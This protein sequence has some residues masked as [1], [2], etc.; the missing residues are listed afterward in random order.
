MIMPSSQEPT[1][2]TISI[3]IA[4]T[5]REKREIYRLRYQ[6]YV[7]EMAMQP[8]AVDHRHKLLYEDLDDWGVL[9]Y[10]KVGSQLIG[11]MRINLGDI[12]AF[13]QNL[14]QIFSLDKFQKFY[15]SAEPQNIAY[16][17][18]LMVVPHYRNSMTLYLL[19]VKGYEFYCQHQVQFTFGICK[20]HLLNRIT[21]AN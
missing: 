2:P 7:E 9:F 12:K 20:F 8:I 19:M 21:V 11:T 14:V 13:P 15:G 16:C 3:G 5:L 18:K 1:Q 10:A 6:I 4:T 17:S